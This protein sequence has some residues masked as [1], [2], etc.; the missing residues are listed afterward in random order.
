MKLTAVINTFEG[1]R[2][3]SRGGE[4][5]K[6][7]VEE[8]AAPYFRISLLGYAPQEDDDARIFVTNDEAD[9]LDFLRRDRWGDDVVSAGTT[10]RRLSE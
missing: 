3:G 2:R 9:A 6:D 8:L 4:V 5:T 10:L 7:L 1:L